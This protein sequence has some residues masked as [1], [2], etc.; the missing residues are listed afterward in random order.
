MKPIP[1]IS[2]FYADEHGRIWRFD[3]LTRVR[4]HS[5]GYLMISLPRSLGGGNRYVHRLVCEAYHGA[6]PEG[7]HCRHL[8]GRRSNNVPSNLCWGTKAENE[9]DKRRHGTLLQGASVGGAVLTDAIVKEARERAARGE[10][11]L[12]LAAEYG[13][14]AHTLT[15]AIMGRKWKHLGGALPKFQTRRKLSADDVSEIKSLYSRGHLQREIAARFGVSQSA[16]SHVLHG[17]TILAAESHRNE[18]EPA[19]RRCKMPKE[20]V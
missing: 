16:I 18:I 3:R 7:M 5:N 1:S 20:M 6:C 2:G 4:S 11:P 9:A 19:Q 17:K 13:V 10:I 15:D 8:D 12:D 14:N